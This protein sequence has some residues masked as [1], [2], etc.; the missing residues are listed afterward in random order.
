M[1]DADELAT[2]VRN[3]PSAP[4][5]GRLWQAVYGLEH[6]WLLPTGDAADPRPMVG[7][8]E[9]ATFL[10]AFT[11]DRHVKDF[12][13]RQGGPVDEAGIP[14]M[15]ITPKD[16]TGLAPTVVGQGVA[17]ILLDQGLHSFVAPVTALQALWDQFG[18]AA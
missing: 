14:A 2:A 7:V 5:V 13:S 6:W 15:S 18:A 9:D 1:T 10:L 17:G 12:A 3:D 16:V 8:V 11:S 4:K